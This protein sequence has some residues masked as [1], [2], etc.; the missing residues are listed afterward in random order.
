MSRVTPQQA[1]DLARD[2]RRG[3]A[4]HAAV[5]AALEDLAAQIEAYQRA[6]VPVSAPPPVPVLLAARAA[7]DAVL[8]A[9]VTAAHREPPGTLLSVRVVRA[10]ASSQVPQKDVFDA[11]ALALAREGAIVLHHHDHP[12]GLSEQERAQLVHDPVMG[13]YYVGIAPR[14]K[15]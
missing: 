2:L 12:W 10:L 13:L 9:V 8:A 4:L 3:R 5:A 15:R 1:R 6:P 11:A 14:E 7:R